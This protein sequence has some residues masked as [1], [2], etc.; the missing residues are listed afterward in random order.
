M[1]EPFAP[2]VSTTV[3]LKVT[4]RNKFPIKDMYD[5]VP[6]VFEPSKALKI[7]LDAAMHIFGWHP[8]AT[9]EDVRKYTCRRMG[10]NTAEM[11]KEGLD[12]QYFDKIKFQP[13]TYKLVELSD[14]DDPAQAGLEFVHTQGGKQF[15]P[16]KGPEPPEHPD[17]IE[18]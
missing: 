11:M 9:N 15:K 7:P 18:K 16:T 3:H 17:L 6:F 13:I 4:N 10:W 8:D 12:R 1:L 5:G 2:E 14:E